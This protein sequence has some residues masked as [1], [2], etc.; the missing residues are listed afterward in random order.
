[1][2]REFGLTVHEEVDDEPPDRPGGDVAAVG[3]L[4]GV[5]HA[6]DGQDEPGVGRSRWQKDEE[7]KNH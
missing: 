2:W 4:V 7:K 6:A 5:H 1:M 3:A